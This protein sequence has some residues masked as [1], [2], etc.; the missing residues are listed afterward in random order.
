MCST[1][2]NSLYTSGRHKSVLHILAH[3]IWSYWQIG[4]HPYHSYCWHFSQ[5]STADYYE[6]R[7]GTSEERI[8]CVEGQQRVT[9]NSYLE[10]IIQLFPCVILKQIKE[11]LQYWCDQA[12]Q[13]SDITN[14]TN[15]PGPHLFLTS[16]LFLLFCIEH[17]FLFGFWFMC[18]PILLGSETKS[19]LLVLVGRLKLKNLHWRNVYWVNVKIL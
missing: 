14:W 8:C 13:E 19:Y 12:I 17:M 2:N 9:S 5:S 4:P 16:Y 3:K 11:L 7:A 18:L 10:A 15:W 1:T 6:N